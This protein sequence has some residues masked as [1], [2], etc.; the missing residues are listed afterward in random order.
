MTRADTILAAAGAGERLAELHDPSG[1]GAAWETPVPL[2]ARQRL[3]TYPADA[4]PGWV[5]DQVTAVAEFTQTPIDLAG[6]LALAA[7]STAAGG[8]AIVNV[9]GTWIEPVNIFTVVAMPPGSRKSAVFRAM[10]NPCS[11]QR[12]TS[13]NAPNPR[14]SKPT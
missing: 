13:P 3:P 7:L 6:C 10:T 12:S 9:R 5:A 1:T 4:L 8:R 14:S 11:T 2:G